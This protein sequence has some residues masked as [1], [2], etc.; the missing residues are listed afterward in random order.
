MEAQLNGPGGSLPLTAQQ[1]LQLSEDP[2]SFEVR[3]WGT[4]NAANLLGKGDEAIL[5]SLLQRAETAGEMM[6]AFTTAIIGGLGQRVAPLDVPWTA[7]RLRRFLLLGQHKCDGSLFEVLCPLHANARTRAMLAEALF[8]EPAAF[9]AAIRSI[10]E[11]DRI[12]NPLVDQV[13]Y[14]NGGE[15]ESALHCK[16]WHA[17]MLAVLERDWSK[18]DDGNRAAAVWIVQQTMRKEGS[19][20][21][22][23]TFLENKKAGAA[24]DV[25]TA[26]EALFAKLAG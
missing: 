26:I 4:Q 14:P 19:L 22:I 6:G 10:P 8:G 7:A 17:T 20:D 23:R 21:A 15:Q 13:A 11:T 25:R 1:W 3:I 24:E 12:E 9:V 2:L 16:R 5:E 18:W